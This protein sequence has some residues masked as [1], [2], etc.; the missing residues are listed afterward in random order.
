MAQHLTRILGD[1]LLRKVL[2]GNA[3]SGLPSG[4]PSPEDLKGKILLKGKK[5]GGLEGHLTGVVE[6]SLAGEVSDED[7]GGEI[8]EDLQNDTIRRRP[9]VSHQNQPR[10]S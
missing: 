10:H 9:K 2:D 3:N 7:D 8:D 4:L 5:I 6:D 1:K